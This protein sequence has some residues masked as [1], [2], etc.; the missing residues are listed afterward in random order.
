MPKIHL[1]EEVPPLFPSKH[2]SDRKML[3]H[4][5]QISISDTAAMRPV[6]VSSVVSYSLP[7]DATDVM[8][9]DNLA[10]ALSTQIQIS[11]ALKGT[12]GKP[13]K[14]PIDLANRWSITLEKAQNTIQATTQREIWT[15]LHP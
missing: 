7:Q 2:Y 4:Q 8:D 10:T 11:I 15:M 6:H 5:G 13:S 3:N 14:E 12:V 9:D 1:T